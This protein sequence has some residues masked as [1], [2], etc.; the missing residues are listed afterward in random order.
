MAGAKLDPDELLM[1]FDVSYL[2]TNVPIQEAVDVIHGR[3]QDDEAVGERTALQ[4]NSIADLLE[5]CLHC[6][7]F[8]FNSRVYEQREEA[9]MG[10]PV[11]AVVAN[12]Y[13]EHFK[14]LA[15]ECAPLRPRVWKR[16]VDDMYYIVRSGAVEEFH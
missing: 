12:L 13:M 2:F 14:K 9:A 16:Y 5:L 10:L 4:P 15:L 6:T 7:Y 1:S 3:L 8:Y 11:S